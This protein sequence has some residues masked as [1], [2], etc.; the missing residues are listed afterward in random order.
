MVPYG[1]RL[2]YAFR[3]FFSILD[4]SRIPDDVL[5]ALHPGARVGGPALHPSAQ[6]T[7][8]GDP[9]LHSRP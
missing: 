1:T 7:R 4:R 6:T 8:A 9:A 5:A 3:T 2:K